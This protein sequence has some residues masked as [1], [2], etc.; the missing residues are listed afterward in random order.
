MPKFIVHERYYKTYE[1]EADTFEDAK[2]KAYS[3]DQ[4]GEFIFDDLAYITSEN[5]DLQIYS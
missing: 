3:D 4:N 5:G 2:Q 1:V